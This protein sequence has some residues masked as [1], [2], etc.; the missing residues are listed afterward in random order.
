VRIADQ[1][2]PPAMLKEGQPR[3]E[4]APPVVDT[5]PAN[6][7]GNE[8]VTPP[9]P[10]EEPNPYE[11][12]NA[13]EEAPNIVLTAQDRA[14]YLTFRDWMQKGHREMAEALREI[15]RRCLWKAEYER[16]SDFCYSEVG[17]GK[18]WVSRLLKW[19]RRQEFLGA[20]CKARN[21]PVWHI[22]KAEGDHLAELE[23]HPEEY[24]RA[25]VETHVAYASRPKGS[26]GR[27]W[28]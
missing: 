11:D 16:W 24:A 20:L 4:D 8:T 1:A 18:M 10:T 28:G 22:T 21:I 23:A 17:H 25:L 27:W 5:T 13:P 26:T 19:L 2:P 7:E 14:D 6:E 3:A 9:A 15:S 12:E